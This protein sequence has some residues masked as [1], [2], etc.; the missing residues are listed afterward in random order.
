MSIKTLGTMKIKDIIDLIKTEQGKK[1]V[2]IWNEIGNS[3]CDFAWDVGSKGI[4]VG[5]RI[6]DKDENEEQ[7]WSLFINYDEFKEENLMLDQRQHYLNDEESEKYGRSM[8]T[9]EEAGWWPKKGIEE[10][11]FGEN[12]RYFDVEIHDKEKKKKIIY[13]LFDDDH[14]IKAS[15]DNEKLEKEAD[16]TRQKRWK[17]KEK[18][19]FTVENAKHCHVHEVDFEE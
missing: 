11:M 6:E 16:E 2:L 13:V 4:L 3:Q 10:L 17:G 9:R 8:G 7:G 14:P 1:I 12:D 19:E 15:F 5:A 18:G